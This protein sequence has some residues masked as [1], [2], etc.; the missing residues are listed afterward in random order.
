[1]SSL[2]S[3]STNGQVTQAIPMSRIITAPSGFTPVNGDGQNSGHFR[4]GEA[5]AKQEPA[6]QSPTFVN[7]VPPISQS[8]THGWR[9]DTRRSYPPQ[10]ESLEARK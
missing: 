9:P 2:A 10:A 1:M 4:A 5:V 8:Q 6:A 7:S 3:T